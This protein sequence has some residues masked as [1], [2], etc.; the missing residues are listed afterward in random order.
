MPRS[1]CW[2]RCWSSTGATCDETPRQGSRARSVPGFAPIHYPRAVV[3]TLPPVVL[4]ASVAFVVGLVIGSF[5]NVVAH[6]VPRG[7]SVVWP[8]S[9]CPRCG[10]RI[11]ARDNVPLLSFL[12][13]RGRCRSCGA[14]ISLRYPAVELA[15]GLV[16]ALVA[17]VH[18]AQPITLLWLAFAAALLAAALVDLD[19]GIIPDSISLGGLVV[20]LAAVPAIRSLEGEPYPEALVASVLGAALGGGLLWATGFLHARLSVAMGRTFPHWPGE[21]EAP[22]RPASLDYWTWFPGLGFGDVKLMAMIGSFLGPLAVLETIFAAA[23]IGLV[24]GGA[25]ALVRRSWAS[26]FGFGPAIAAGALAVLTTPVHL[27]PFTG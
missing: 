20:G 5:L 19:Q 18:G 9:H 1:S 24:A 27:L 8:P 7:E 15:T 3:L 13:L 14:R 4:L 26:P 21:D 2:A 25:A 12:W 23:A 17:A 22:P 6:R 11:A 16:F 10:G